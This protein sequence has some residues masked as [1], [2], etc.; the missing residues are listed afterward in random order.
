MELIKLSQI[1]V[2]GLMKEKI[3]RF[4][5]VKSGTYDR[6]DPTAYE[7]GSAEFWLLYGYTPPKSNPNH[8]CEHDQD[9]PPCEGCKTNPVDW[10]PPKPETVKAEFNDCTWGT[11]F[12]F[13]TSI[14]TIQGYIDHDC[15]GTNPT[16]IT[17]DE[18]FERVFR[19]ILFVD[20]SDGPEDGYGRLEDYE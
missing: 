14:G 1:E 17:H 8:Q 13:H 5:E 10:C 19:D 11:L 2:A 7:R 18:H 6:A 20:P 4:G 15:G 3:R 12:K 16:W 9:D